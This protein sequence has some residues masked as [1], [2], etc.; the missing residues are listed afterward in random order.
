MIYRMTILFIALL[1]NQMSACSAY[2]YNNDNKL[3]AKNF[4]WHSGE[5]YIIKNVKGQV[6]YAYGFRNSNV[7]KWTSKYGSITFNQIGKEFPYGGINEKGLVIEQL[8]LSNSQYKEN[9]NE[10][11]SELEW[12][13]Y[14]LD[15]Y[16][17]IDEV[18]KH[19]DDLTIKPNASIHFIL[20]DKTG[21]STVIEFISGNVVIN[22]Q[23][24]AIQVVTNSTY[25]SSLL[26]YNK[27]KDVD[28]SSRKS[29]DRY[30]ILRDSLTTHSLTVN[31]A[32]EKLNLVKETGDNYK[33]YWSIVYD[34]DNLEVH[35]K[36]YNT[37]NIKTIFLA[38][39]DFYQGERVEYTLINRNAVEFKAYDINLNDRLFSSAMKMMNLKVNEKQ[40]S[41]HQMN[42][43][44]VRIDS[45]FQ[46]NYT[47]LNIEFHTKHDKGIIWYSLING[48]EN[49]KT[50]A[51]YKMGIT[52]VSGRITR[53]TVYNIPKADFAL[54]CFLDTNY[55][56]KMDTN[57]LGIP[58]NTGFSNNKKRIF[59]IPPNYKT[60][61][62]ALD[63]TKTI[64]IDIK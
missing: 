56:S 57:F 27:T 38:D 11:I 43:G 10:E 40:A 34:I 54:A 6:K 62:V 42:P 14:Q 60:A 3:L 55:D 5:G 19:V 2:F 18:I 64:K 47:D 46:S 59:G 51:G 21:S 20:A 49:F 35:F 31:N 4:D 48:K 8:W 22:R 7:A 39:L 58:K 16:A 53:I 23:D 36:S 17:T 63:K 29:L 9:N 13:Q 30:C 32:F 12:I 24:G 45:I 37:E 52:P 28:I 44:S 33:T 1:Y 41:Y 26:Y 25:R 15:N 61:K 50:Y